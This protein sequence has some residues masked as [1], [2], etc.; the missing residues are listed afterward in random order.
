MIYNK[1]HSTVKKEEKNRSVLPL[2]LG[3][4]TRHPSTGAPSILSKEELKRSVPLDR[5]QLVVSP[6]KEDADYLNKKF[7]Q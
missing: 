3:N 6:V 5:H 2:N 7:K 4:T 1:R